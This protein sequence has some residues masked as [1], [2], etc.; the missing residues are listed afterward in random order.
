MTEEQVKWH[1]DEW[2]SKCVVHSISPR[3]QW[4]KKGVSGVFSRRDLGGKNAFCGLCFNPDLDPFFAETSL[5]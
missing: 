5:K 1:Y 4:L 3:N 2:N